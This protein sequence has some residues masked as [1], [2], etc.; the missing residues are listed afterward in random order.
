MNGQPPPKR[1]GFLDGERTMEEDLALIIDIA[2][3]FHR[4]IEAHELEPAHST[5]ELAARLIRAH[6]AEPMDLRALLIADEVDLVVRVSEA[7][8]S[9]AVL[10]HRAEVIECRKPV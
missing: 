1:R 6:N 2:C 3:R 8:R 7:I 10:P 4:V 5:D 9:Q